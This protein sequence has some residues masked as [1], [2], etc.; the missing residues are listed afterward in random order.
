M[1]KKSKKSSVSE[2]AVDRPYTPAILTRARAIADQYQLVMWRED[3][4]WYGRGVEVPNAMDDGKTPDECAANVREALVSHVAYLLEKGEAPPPAVATRTRAEQ[5]NL[6]L[7]ADEKLTLETAAKQGGFG[8]VSDFVR[9]VA[10][11]AA[12]GQW[13]G[14]EREKPKSART[15]I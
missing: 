2:G 13:R 11:K 7:T 9:T 6:R 15:S 10:M 8:G 1:S 14:R 5:I 4:E 12:A 3:G